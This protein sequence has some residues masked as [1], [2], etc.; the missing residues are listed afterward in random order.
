MNKKKLEQKFNQ[1]K[2]GLGDIQYQRISLNQQ[3]QQILAQI[4]ETQRDYQKLLQEEKPSKR[5]KSAK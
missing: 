1:L 3:E 5:D 2:S 4:Q